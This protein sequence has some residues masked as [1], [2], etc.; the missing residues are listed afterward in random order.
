MVGLRKC[1]RD[2]MERDGRGRGKGRP[3]GAISDFS[4]GDERLKGYGRVSME[5]FLMKGCGWFFRNS[6][7]LLMGSIICEV[8]GGRFYRLGDL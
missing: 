6:S 7:L 1:D 4:L 3:K 8:G 5:S 2:G